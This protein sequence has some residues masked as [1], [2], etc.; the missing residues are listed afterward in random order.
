M[1]EPGRTDTEVRLF[2]IDIPQPDLDD[3][4]DRLART[5][6]P[7]ELLGVGW[8]RGVPFDYIKE[9]AE[10][11]REGYDWRKW[12]ARLNEFPQYTTEIDGQTIHYP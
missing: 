2:R 11:W 1:T 5:R 6:W 10:Y 9:L 12:E 3:L 8:S 7:D 4:H